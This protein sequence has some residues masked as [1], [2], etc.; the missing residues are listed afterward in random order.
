MMRTCVIHAKQ[1][2]I[3][4]FVAVGDQHVTAVL[5]AAGAGSRFTGPGH[6]LLAELPSNT[7]RPAERVVDRALAAVA[8]AEVD[9]IIVVTGLLDAGQLGLDASQPFT[10]LHN[11]RWADGQMTSVQV[12]LTA[13]SA[14][15]ADA[16]VVGL[17]DQPGITSQAWN[18]VAG[19][20][21]AD[22]PIAVATYDGTRGNP[23]AMHRTMWHLLPRSGD[24]GARS[25]MRIRGD[26]VVEVSCQGQPQDIDTV[27]DLQQW[28]NN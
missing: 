27:E 6:K 25:L 16:V 14:S 28:Q 8:G 22:A 13:A 4:R 9:D 2:L 21:G 17:A 7:T 11:P 1:P 3:R 24:A 18:D 19:R 15:G 10:T 5:L 26:L 12:G 20:V 23:V